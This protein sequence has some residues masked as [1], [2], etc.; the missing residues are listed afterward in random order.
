MSILKRGA[1]LVYTFRFIRMMVMDWKNWD[2][3]KEGVIYENVKRIKAV[4]LDTD[5]KKNSYTPFIRLA[6][7]IKRLV[8]KLPGGGSKLGSFASALFLIK[9]QFRLD[10]NQLNRILRELNVDPVDLIAEQ[11]QW[12]ILKDKQLSPGIYRIKEDK[13][14][15]Q[16]FEE[17]VNAK[18]KIKISQDCYPTGEVF[19]IDIYE[20]IHMNTNKKVYVS[21]SELSK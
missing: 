2:A 17:L 14:I 5:A 6:A 13:M 20:G 12:F 15:N 19:G 18:D 7:N 11:S 10:D 16:L 9:E 8:S 3:Y 21:A 4:K 1:D